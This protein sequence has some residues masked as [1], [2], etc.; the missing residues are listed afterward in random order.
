M[1][2]STI[3]LHCSQ[4]SHKFRWSHRFSDKAVQVGHWQACL[5][6]GVWSVTVNYDVSECN[7]ASNTQCHLVAHM[8]APVIAR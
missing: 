7:M 1:T 2:F 3:D 4:P 6:W 5:R 8:G